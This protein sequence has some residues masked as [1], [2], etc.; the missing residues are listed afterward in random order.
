MLKNDTTSR[1]TIQLNPSIPDT[2]YTGNL[3]I[4][5][6]ACGPKSTNSYINNPFKQESLLNWKLCLVLSGL[7]GIHCTK[8]N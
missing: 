1:K 5:N 7:Q 4:Q 8:K 2:L 3:S 6:K